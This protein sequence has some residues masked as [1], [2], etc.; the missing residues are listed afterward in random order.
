MVKNQFFLSH[1]EEKE[2]YRETIISQ[3]SRLRE[4]LAAEYGEGSRRLA[5]PVRRSVREQTGGFDMVLANPPYVNMVEMDAT[6]PDYRNQVRAHFESAS[7]GFDLFVPFMERGCQLLRR[8]G[9]FSY[10]VP[11]KVLS[12]EYAKALRRYFSQH[13]K[14]VSLT[15]LSRIPVF[16]AAVYPFIIIA[17]KNIAPVEDTC[18]DIYG[19][20]GSSLDDVRIEHRAR[21]SMDVTVP[22]KGRWSPLVEAASS[23]RLAAAIRHCPAFEALA[24][25]SGAATVS[26]AYEWKDAVINEGDSLLKRAPKRYAR[27]IVSGNVRRYYHTWEDDKVQYIKYGY[28]HPVLDKQHDAVSDNRVRQIE[29]AKLIISGMSK[30]PTCVWDPGGIAAGKS[31]VIVIPKTKVDGRYLAAVMNSETMADIYRMLFGSLS[32][33]GGYLRFGPP[34]VKALP[35]PEASAGEQRT[36]GDLADKCERGKGVGCEAWERELDERVAK[37]YGL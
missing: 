1:G 16:S 17:E 6:D 21:A 12:A 11:N 30:R 37:L 20:T 19:T 24:D 9:S 36:L 32:L 23:G 28:W 27:F 10:I 26:E 29:A 18:V 25:V 22:M 31:T 4:S 7:G 2:S 5:N 15:D 3:E 8:G 34:Q 35:I 14:L 13:M 33:S